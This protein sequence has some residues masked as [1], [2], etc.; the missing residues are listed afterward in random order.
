LPVQPGRAARIRRPPGTVAPPG[1]VIDREEC[2]QP[3]AG[4]FVPKWKIRAFGKLFAA[5][6]ANFLSLVSIS[7]SSYQ[8][9]LLSAP[10]L[11]G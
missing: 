2:R 10:D 5:A 4:N 7:A 6:L 3:A 8:L 9:R 1:A 11:S